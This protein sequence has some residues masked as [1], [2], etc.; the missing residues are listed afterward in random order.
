MIKKKLLIITT[1]GTIAMRYDDEFG[2]VQ[3]DELVDYLLNFPQLKH[4]ADIDVFEFSNLP[5]PYI[6]PELMFR[7]ASVIE[8]KVIEYDGI[9]IT[10]GTDTLEETAYFLD[11][12]LTTPKP[13]VLTAAMRNGSDLGLDGPRNII[14]AVRVASSA[15]ARNR[16]VLVVMNDEIDSARDVVKTDTGKTN[17]FVSLSYGPLGII[18]PDKV[19][20]FR[21]SVIKEKIPADKLEPNIDLIKCVSGMDERYLKCSI[22]SGAKGIVLEAFGRGNVPP[23][24]LDTISQ[25]I[26][27]NII[28]V[29]VSRSY[30]GRVLPEYGYKGGGRYLQQL[31]A[32]LGGDLRGPK[33]R[34][35]LML[36]FGKYSNPDLVRKYL[37]HSNY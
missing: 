5:S 10:H 3:N 25:A 36:L 28:V 13:V 4:V 35:K 7:L 18:D 27:K 21:D 29:V 16:G 23:G 37:L 34:I 31:G 11:L 9:I 12:V 17:S 32:I 19:I 24:I 8:E 22:A 20:F 1:G 15:E 30:T 33:M 14:G 26:E 6:T 2:V